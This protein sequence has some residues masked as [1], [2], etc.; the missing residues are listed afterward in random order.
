MIGY[1]FEVEVLRHI[2]AS[3]GNVLICFNVLISEKSHITLLDQSTQVLRV[4]NIS[5]VYSIKY[6]RSG[7]TIILQQRAVAYLEPIQ[8]CSFFVKN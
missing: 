1:K 8:T 6:K 7:H 5:Y 4:P 3:Q 2:R